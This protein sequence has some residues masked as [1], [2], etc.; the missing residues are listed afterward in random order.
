MKKRTA[1]PS[2]C[3][4]CIELWNKCVEEYEA[5][6]PKGEFLNFRDSATTC[7]ECREIKVDQKAARELR[8]LEELARR[9][10]VIDD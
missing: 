4:R 9:L 2:D 1:G 3:T 5:A 8:N 7:E 6:L 10:G